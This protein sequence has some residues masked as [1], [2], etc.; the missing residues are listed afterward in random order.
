MYEYVGID[1]NGVHASAKKVQGGIS[2]DEIFSLMLRL[3]ARLGH[4]RDEAC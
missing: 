4:S 1:E 2:L 3:P